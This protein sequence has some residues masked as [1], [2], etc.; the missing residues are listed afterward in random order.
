MIYTDNGKLTFSVYY[1]LEA[2]IIEEDTIAKLGNTSTS[3]I[4][5]ARAKQENRM[6]KT[7]VLVKVIQPPLS[8][9]PPKVLNV[10]CKLMGGF[11]EDKG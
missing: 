11:R 1:A 4:G 5:A 10:G 6:L 2:Y 7:K 9:N 8:V 3:F